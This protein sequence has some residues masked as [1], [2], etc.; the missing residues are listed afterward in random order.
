[1]AFPYVFDYRGE[2]RFDVEPEVLWTK[3][4]D[5]D[6][7]R[8]WWPWMRDLA[9]TGRPLDPGSE[10]RFKV[11]SPLPWIMRLTVT[12]MDSDRPN[13]VGAVVDGHL[14]GSAELVFTPDGH[15]TLAEVSWNVE[16]VD[17]AMRVGARVARPVMKWGQDWAV[18]TALRRFSSH[19]AEESDAR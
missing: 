5:T 14:R 17:R 4:V 16:V 1:V 9:V 3:L 11:V 18:R 8:E 15:E 19:L 13:T 12:V 10:F 2:F 7:Y 6:R